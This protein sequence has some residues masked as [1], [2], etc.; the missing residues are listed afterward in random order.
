VKGLLI[1]GSCCLGG[2]YAIQE[3]TMNS[4]TGSSWL[5]LYGTSNNGNVISVTNN[6]TSGCTQTFTYD[7]LDRVKVADD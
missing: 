4:K 7:E 1:V 5:P 2:R 3:P 6:L